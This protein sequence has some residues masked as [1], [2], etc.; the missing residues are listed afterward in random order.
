MWGTL[1]SAPEII[2]GNT[3]RSVFWRG[4]LALAAGILIALE[5][6]LTAYTLTVWFGWGLLSGGIWIVLSSCYHRK[7]GWAFYGG[8]TA[9]AALLPV[10]YPGAGVIA[11]AWCIGVV[12]LGSGIVKIHICLALECS[13]AENLFCFISSVF[14]IL[15]GFLLFW[16]PVSGMA[17]LFWA[18][19]ILMMAGGMTQI[20]FSLRIPGAARGRD[21]P[22]D[23]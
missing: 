15:L 16:C 12:L 5:P 6:V 22:H 11:L 23:K 21:L 19:G 3:R 7:W 2:A 4:L 1:F 8:L 18:L 13:S 20:V 9:F 14:S 17:D 10:F